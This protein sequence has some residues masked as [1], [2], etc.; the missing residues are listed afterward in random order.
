MNSKQEKPNRLI[1][2]LSP[3]L[4]Q[5]AYN[6]VEWFPWSNEAFEKAEKEDKPI[7]LSIGYSTCH[8]CH[9][10]ENESF[11]DEATAEILNKYFVA[12]KVDRE[13]RP[14]IDNV[15]M[16]ACQI[17]S[18]SGGWPLSLFLTS[19]KNPF[20]A[21]TYFPNTDRYGRISFTELLNKINLAWKTN[22]DKL[23]KASDE[24]LVAINNRASDRET[25]H[26]PANIFETAYKYFENNFDSLHG[27]FGSSPKFPSPHNLIFLLRYWKNYKEPGA[28][29]IVNKTL[30]EMHKGGIFDHVGFGFH[31]Y[32]TDREWLVPH[33]EKMLY[34]QALLTLA[35]TEAFLATN[36]LE[37]KIA[38]EQILDY[39]NREMTSLSGG[40]YSAED[41]D[42][43][44]V[45]GKFYFWTVD[46]LSACLS[47]EEKR[48][49]VTVYNIGNENKEKN[50][51][52]HR[53]KSFVDLA[54]L[55]EMDLKTLLVQKESIRTKM[56]AYRQARIHPFK[57]DKILTD[58]NGLM[59]G[60]FANAGRILNNNSYVIAAE[61]A[62][63]FIEAKLII[64]EQ[65]FH[66]SRNDAAGVDAN[67]DDY[68][69]LVFGLIELYSSTYKAEYLTYAVDLVNLTIKHFWDEENRGFYFTPSN[70]EKL[71]T[72]TKDIYDG[73][74]PSGNSVMLYNLVKLYRFTIN[75]TYNDYAVKTI[76]AFSEYIFH[77]P[78]ASTLFL[79]A[80]HL[81]N[82]EST[83]VIIVG[84][85]EEENVKNF[86]A[87][88]S[89]L[90]LP[91]LS[92]L[93]HDSEGDVYSLPFEYLAL[94]KKVNSQ[95][96]FYVCK[97]FICN[98][99]V[100]DVAEAIKQIKD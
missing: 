36:N 6:P 24:I 98:L 77:S 69:F 15:Y 59:I 65:L 72:R 18:G 91:N 68:A 94:Y 71:I 86:L 11:V 76:G 42:S 63:G 3:Y 47:D 53:S 70:G 50:K 55:L 29:N 46:D 12:I 13:E 41:A 30:S 87:S 96:T 35:Y 75:K 83:E 92:I 95:A 56:F 33:F 57:D 37:F 60:A 8:W 90:F 74:I 51:I 48:F 21:G 45:E 26:I 34:D 22:R 25:V 27:G 43:E 89:S 78:F 82:S 93:V 14:D 5:H 64:D 2:E 66:R 28:I 19:K 73:A 44:G 85:P 7:F 31:R 54:I 1:N 100:N 23:E 17:M 49:A 84:S 97:N 80:Y 9:V 67:L 10:M 39:V 99:P 52:P 58:W 81:L 88:V 4:L 38:A 40:F 61:N 20:F 16:T 62:F 79:S 32:S